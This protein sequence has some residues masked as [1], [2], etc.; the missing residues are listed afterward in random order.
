MDALFSSPSG[1]NGSRSLQITSTVTFSKNCAYFLVYVKKDR[2]N[3]E[4]MRTT[5][6]IDSISDLVTRTILRWYGHLH[7]KR[8]DEWVK[9]IMKFEV[10]S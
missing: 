6:G 7:W 1:Q 2:K 3:T 9:K 8:E 4:E 5:M 10:D